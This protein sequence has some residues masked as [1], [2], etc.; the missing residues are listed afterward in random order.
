MSDRIRHRTTAFRGLALALLLV[1]PGASR[2]AAEEP[3]LRPDD[4]A[5]GREIEHTTAAPLQTVLLDLPIYRGTVEPRLA[6]LRVFNGAGEPV[7]HAIRALARPE[8]VDG[9]LVSV[10]LFRLPEL[11][12]GEAASGSTL[13]GGGAGAYGID[14]EVSD[15]G[16]I[17]RI[18]RQSGAGDDATDDAADRPAA[19]LVDTSQLKED[20]VGIEVELG[21]DAVEFVVPV[22]VEGSNDLT[23]FQV[24]GQQ[25]ALARLDQ[26]GHNIETS[27]IEL[28][29]SR[30]RY[31]RLSWPEERLPVA[32]ESV[33]VQLASQTKQPPRHTLRVPG[34]AVADEPGAF[35]FDLGGEIPVDRLQLD[36]P[37]ANTLIDASF[38]SSDAATGPWRHHHSGLVY[39]LGSRH[40]VRNPVLQWPPMRRRYVKL[41]V[42]AKGGGLGSGT[43]ILEASWV[44][45]QL[46]FITRGAPP[47]RLGYGRALVE[48]T[49]FDA[50]DLIR[51]THTRREDVPTETAS[52]GAEYPVAGDS[53][54]TPPKTPVSGRTLALWAVLVGSVGLV[55][56]MSTRLLRQM[57]KAPDAHA[58]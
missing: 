38:F 31:L 26:A 16:A 57:R 52:L 29:K 2:A 13:D 39:D 45:E 3:T 47:F 24:L 23:R 43:P 7:P 53:V 8:K 54:L 11:A 33:R 9:D 17:V 48:H 30:Y 34:R 46:L 15:S 12:A 51:T 35:V 21:L 56:A 40:H 28:P 20:V 18:R 55:M 27:R 19:Y 22:R 44:P 6:D 25:A 14:A 41:V 32:I 58:D 10:P 4:F 50:S 5:H 37:A 36:L 1:S 49:T 42:S